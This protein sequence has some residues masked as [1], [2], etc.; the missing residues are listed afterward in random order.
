MVVVKHGK[1]I[2]YIHI[3][4]GG[5]LSSSCFFGKRVHLFNK[6]RPQNTDV[7]SELGDVGRKLND[8][9]GRLDGTIEG[10]CKRIG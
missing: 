5:L 1:K 10:R 9:V 7:R 8:V 2:P 4:G 3:F 6:I